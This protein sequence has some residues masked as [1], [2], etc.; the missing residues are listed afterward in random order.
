MR[1]SDRS[2]KTSVGSDDRRTRHPEDNSEDRRPACPPGRFCLGKWAPPLLALTMS[3]VA[4][5]GW[6]SERLV[7]NDGSSGVGTPRAGEVPEGVSAEAWEA[8]S[9]AIERDRY[10]AERRE[11]GTVSAANRA[12]A[13]TTRFT[14]EGIRVRPQGAGMG[15]GVEVGLTLAGYG[16]SQTQPVEAAEPQAKGN[17]VEFHRGTLTEWYVNRA[18]GLEQGFTLEEPPLETL[19]QAR[20][21]AGGREPLRLELAVAGPVRVERTEDGE[22]VLLRDPEGRVRLRYGGLRAWDATGRELASRLEAGG[23]RIALLVED[24]AARYPLTIDP[25]ILNEAAKLT[26]GDAAAFDN[27]GQS[28]SISGDTLVVGALHDECTPSGIDCGAAYVF[29]K[30]AGGWAGTLTQDAKLTAS[31]AATGDFFSR[32]VS[33]SGG[34][35]VVGAWTHDCTPSGNDCGAAYVFEKPALGWADGTQDAKLTASDAAANDRFGSSVAISGNTV[36]VGASGDDC[37]PSGN[38]CGS[39]YV[40]L[41]PFLPP[42][43]PVNVLQD[44]WTT[45]LN[46]D[47]D[48]ELE[49]YTFTTA[50]SIDFVWKQKLQETCS[51][52]LASIWVFQCIAGKPLP[53][54]IVQ[55][56]HDISL[57]QQD[58]VPGTP[59]PLLS[60][61][62]PPGSIPPGRYDWALVTECDD[63][64]GRIAGAPVPDSDIDDSCGVNVGVLPVFPGPVMLGPEPVELFDADPGGSPAGRGPGEEGTTRP[65]CF[66]VVSP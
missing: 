1:K 24:A 11:D 7:Q 59:E 53:G 34:T 13:Y 28:V 29:E 32:S 65:W 16:Y 38:D 4:A 14:R 66:T 46:L 27:F 64:N 63:T 33:I 15:A 36:V 45:S 48:P 10:R 37:T 58:P 47:P 31:D 41:G 19:Q 50:D 20:T 55:V 5:P 25:T 22:A 43:P 62:A 60:F 54:A 21:R 39:A 30:P 61:S 3:F 9:G 35:V 51:A 6:A 23:G 2:P 49:L 18:A 44:C 26:A 40:F 17:R 56:F 42:P 52:Y 8:I 57:G 12:Q